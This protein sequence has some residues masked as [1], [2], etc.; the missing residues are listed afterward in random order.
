MYKTHVTVKRKEQ[1][2]FFRKECNEFL[3]ICYPIFGVAVPL[4][5]LVVA[6]AI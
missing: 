1:S 5:I 2:N 3:V 4:Q 6:T